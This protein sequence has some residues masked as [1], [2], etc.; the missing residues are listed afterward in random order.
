MMTA[1]I[2]VDSGENNDDDDGKNDGGDD[3]DDD[4]GGVVKSSILFLILDDE[5]NERR[6]RTS[7]EFSVQDLPMLSTE[8]EIHIRQL[9]FEVVQ[10]AIND[11]KVL[12][13]AAEG[14]LSPAAIQETSA[15][16]TTPL[17][18]SGWF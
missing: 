17:D 15:S 2:I 12:I 1:V 8:D 13:A 5:S 11:A 3:D 4:L 10:T 14:S 7:T 6:Q 16:E 18:G 9:S